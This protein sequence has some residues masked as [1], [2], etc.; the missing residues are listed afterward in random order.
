MMT[1]ERGACS[2]AA[3]A[4]RCAESYRRHVRRVGVIRLDSAAFHRILFLM[5]APRKVWHTRAFPVNLHAV[6]A[7]RF[8]NGGQRRF[9][10]PLKSSARGLRAKKAHLMRGK[11]GAAQIRCLDARYSPC[12]GRPT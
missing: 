11:K 7:S 5:C 6:L 12:R 2:P 9:N 3:L 8:R 1:A 4:S 10:A